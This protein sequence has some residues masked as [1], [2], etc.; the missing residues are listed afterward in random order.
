MKV[1]FAFAA[2]ALIM[3]AAT[4]TSPLAAEPERS[5]VIE[6]LQAQCIQEAMLRGFVGESMKGF[7][8]ACVELK[9]QLPA[10]DPRLYSADSGAC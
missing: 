3:G 9:R 1:G 10:P 8:H 5:P 2:A 4:A 6:F 7:V